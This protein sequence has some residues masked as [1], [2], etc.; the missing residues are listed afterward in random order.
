MSS[1]SSIQQAREHHRR[2]ADALAL[3]ERHRQQRDAFIRRARQEDPVRWSYGALAAAVG[4]SKELIAAIIKG[5][6]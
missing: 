4:C 1:D 5:R 3:A 6:V 2:A